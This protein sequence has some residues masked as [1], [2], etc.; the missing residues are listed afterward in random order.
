MKCSSEH[1]L[2]TER[3]ATWSAAEAD[4]RRASGIGPPWPRGRGACARHYLRGADRLAGHAAARD[5]PGPARD[6]GAAQGSSRVRRRRATPC[7]RGGPA[8]PSL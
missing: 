4:G 6:A 1:P 8:G 3:G 5:G 7:A 2:W